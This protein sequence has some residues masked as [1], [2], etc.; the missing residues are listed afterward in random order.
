MPLAAMVKIMFEFLRGKECELH[1][2][3][4][5]DLFYIKHTH[6]TH[7][8]HTDKSTNKQIDTQKTLHKHKT[9]KKKQ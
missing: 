1:Y 4:H 3:H 7:K 8:Q 9:D 2:N 6:T 5:N